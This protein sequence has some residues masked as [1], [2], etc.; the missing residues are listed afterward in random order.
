MLAAI[1][2]R[3]ERNWFIKM[4]GPEAVVDDYEKEFDRFVRS[5]RINE[6]EKP[7]LT[8]EVPRGWKRKPG[9]AVRFATFTFGPKDQP[10]ELAVLSLGGSVFDNINRWRKQL[11]L[12]PIS[13]DE[14]GDV[15]KKTTIH[16]A[17]AY[18]VDMSGTGSGK[19]QAPFAGARAGRQGGPPKVSYD[20][21]RGW[22]KLR[23]AGPMKLAA[24]RVSGGGEEAQ[25]AITP[26]APRAADLSLM[27]GLWCDELKIGKGEA[28]R[29]M[30]KTL[31]RISVGGE[32]ASYV[33]LQSS[34]EEAGRRRILAVVA[35]QGGYAWFFTLKGDAGLVGKQKKAFEQFV[36]SVQFGT[37]QGGDDE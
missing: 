30:K 23:Q 14:L 15:A 22:K 11:D 19:T 2:P 29:Q 36:E 16:G 9:N 33:D 32:R 4:V 25:A 24:F 34:E 28:A 31:R 12:R 27:V 18:L 26:L 21:P 7:P 35:Q 6:E 1:F 37:D 8:W 5:I 3:D 13:K 20:T 10:L 17:P